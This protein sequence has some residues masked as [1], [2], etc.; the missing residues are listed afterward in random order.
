MDYEHELDEVKFDSPSK[1]V[2]EAWPPFVEEEEEGG[3]WDHDDCDADSTPLLIENENFQDEVS[4]CKVVSD[5]PVISVIGNFGVYQAGIAAVG[6]FLTV[7]HSWQSL[8]LKFVAIKTEFNCSEGIG[9][10]DHCTAYWGDNT[11]SKCTK[12]IHDGSDFTETL[13]QRWD[14]VC[15]KEEI[16]NLAQSVFFAGCLVGVFVSGVLADQCGRRPVLLGL[17]VI[18]LLSGVWSG[19]TT[20]LY[21]W[22]ALIFIRGA[23]TIGLNTVRFVIQVE[24]VG[25]PWKVWG[26]AIGSAGWVAGY[27]SLPVLAWLV[28]NMAWMEL[29]I[30][31][32]GLPLLVMCWF[33][34]ESPRWL[35]GK[36]EFEEAKKVITSAARWNGRDSSQVSV[37]SLKKFAQVLSSTKTE[38]ASLCSM[39][40]LPNLRRNM[41]CMCV[42]WFAIGMSYFGL[43]LH[44]PEFGS[45]VFL[46]FFIGG[47]M[48]LPSLI[49]GPFMINI[50]GRRFCMTGSLL[51]GAVAL[52]STTVIPK[53]V[54]FK[55]WPIITLAIVGKMAIG[56]AFDVGYIFTTELFP[57]MIRNTVLS[58]ASSAA[59]VG[60]II[61]PLVADIDSSR[62]KLP[63]LIYGLVS[64][65][66]GLQ[67]ILLWPETVDLNKL[68]DT[69]EEGE[70]IARRNRNKKNQIKV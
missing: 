48:D 16:N 5:D 19:V 56:L 40:A 66:A 53:G 44:T 14:L 50:L 33:Y 54:Y 30:G 41:I 32:C 45:N 57:T 25:G 64:L 59:R 21:V 60:A 42:C 15:D 4:S 24:L 58:T 51:S 20:S 52:L 6:F 1:D 11:T 8:C 26:N 23:S 36:G 31:L 13:A 65:M 62:P 46:V 18:F 69:L 43:A 35:I 27:M 55:E 61:A 39:M 29:V 3:G 47:L 49:F 10:P 7:V 2:S 9:G 28:P 68:P 37:S 17:M 22:L 63:I 38:Q 34:P 12:F 70:S 67:S